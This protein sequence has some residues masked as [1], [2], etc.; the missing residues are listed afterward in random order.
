MVGLNCLWFKQRIGGKREM[1]KCDVITS[2]IHVA[3]CLFISVMLYIFQCQQQIIVIR[4][5]CFFCVVIFKVGNKTN[6]QVFWSINYSYK[7]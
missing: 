2:I 7:E 6:I 1:N 5:M 3:G 4:L